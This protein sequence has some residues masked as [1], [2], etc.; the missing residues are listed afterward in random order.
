MYKLP[1]D[2]HLMAQD[3]ALDTR[4]DVLHAVLEGCGYQGLEG[5][6]ARCRPSV[7]LA[8]FTPDICRSV[9]Q[10]WQHGSPGYEVM[11]LICFFNRQEIEILKRDKEQACF[12]LEELST[13]VGY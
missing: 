4:A 11:F 3:I 9:S 10:S 6:K 2:W 7:L 13:Q 5:S 1:H 12:D 8:N